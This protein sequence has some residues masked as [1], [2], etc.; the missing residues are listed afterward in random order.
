MRYNW[1]W[2]HFI[3]VIGFYLVPKSVRSEIENATDTYS[4]WDA[5]IYMAIIFESLAI[6]LPITFLVFK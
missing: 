1:K 4:R 5:L 2:I 6:L 3:P